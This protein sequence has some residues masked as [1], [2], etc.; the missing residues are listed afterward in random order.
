M[1]ACVAHL[2]TIRNGETLSS[3]LLRLAH[4]HS[5]SGHELC[6][7][8]WPRFQFWTR[9]I[10]RT[11]S[12]AL[13]DDISRVTGIG[14]DVLERATLRGLVKATGFQEGMPGCQRG[15]LPV[16]VYHR[17]RRRFGQQYCPV[18]LAEKP[19]YLRKLWRLEFM[20]ACPRHGNL[21]RD[22]CPNCDAPFI[23]HRSHALTKAQCHR[24]GSSLTAIER[25]VSTDSAVM[26]QQSVLTALANTLLDDKSSEVGDC[27]TK[28]FAWTFFTDIE[29]AA[30]LDGVH[31]LCRLAARASDALPHASVS[32]RTVWT[33][34]RVPERVVVMS[35]V[36]RWLSDWPD[37]WVR[38]AINADMTQHYLDHEYGP[39]PGWVGSAIA[40]LP[41]SH[42]PVD[43]RRHRRNLSIRQLR[44]EHSSLA[45]YRQ[46]RAAL[47]LK[48]AGVLSGIRR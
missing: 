17:I 40:R 48:K 21:L 25:V 38:W 18:C 16:G 15:I 20:V 6:T 32:E 3:L 35:L 4:N 14:R 2:P 26:L 30:V 23:P 29:N 42:G 8:L 43:I 27:V 28:D 10:D 5:A 33:L 19:A 44:K 41:Y 39:W 12:D 7:L 31:R 1:T 9:D 11:A 46:A 34:L 24:C 37:E 36:A 22:S 13:L 47:L 45:A